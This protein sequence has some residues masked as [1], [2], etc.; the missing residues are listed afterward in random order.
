MLDA[1]G[2][3]KAVQKLLLGHASIQT[4][5]DIYADW[6]IDQLATPMADVLSEDDEP[7]K[8]KI[9]GSHRKIS[10]NKPK[11]ERTRRWANPAFEAPALDIS[12]GCMPRRGVPSGSSQGQ[13][14][15]AGTSV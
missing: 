4:T 14:S 3:L 2:N 8:A 10:A 15:A 12:G 9:P 13:A 7:P 6:D 5:G 1:T 11:V